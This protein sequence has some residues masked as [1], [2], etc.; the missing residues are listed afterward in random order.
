MARVL[1]VASAPAHQLSKQIVPEIRLVAGLGVE[2]D[3]H[4][5]VT[6]QHQTQVRSDPTRINLRQ[7]HLMHVELFDELAGKGYRLGPAVLGEN[8][9]TQGIDLLSLPRDALLH[10]GADAVIR[11]TGLR[12]PC[13]QLDGFQPGLA[14]AMLGKDADGAL[15]RKAGV[16]GVVIAGGAIRAGDPIDVR[17]P[18]RPFSPLQPV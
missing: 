7:V 15:I 13:R 2:G 1:A 3:A 6:T 14:Q 9:T 18:D 17:L 8:I 5:G 4:L 11:I 10:I 12:N 16:M